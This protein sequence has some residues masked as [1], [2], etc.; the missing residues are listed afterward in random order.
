MAHSH[1]LHSI[2][3]ALARQNPNLLEM[4][5]RV[6]AE[7]ALN[8]MQAWLV[9]LNEMLNLNRPMSPE[10]IK[11]CAQQ[12]LAEHNNLKF[13]E[14]SYLFKRIISGE[15]GEFYESLSIAKVLTFFRKYEQE[16]LEV[17]MERQRQQ[18]AQ[19]KETQGEAEMFLRKVK[20]I[21]R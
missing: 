7:F 16:R 6:S 2:E 9:Y 19:Y 15:F 5:A 12:I 3:E 18:H 20:K 11:L 14:L 21:R 8:L 17:V 10:Q 1:K 13:S 4:R